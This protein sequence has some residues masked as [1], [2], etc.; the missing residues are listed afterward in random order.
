MSVENEREDEYIEAQK[1][2]GTYI[3]G[4]SY[5]REP[6]KD[7]RPAMM[8]ERIRERK[9]EYFESKDNEIVAPNCRIKKA[10][11]R[12]YREVYMDGRCANVEQDDEEQENS[13]TM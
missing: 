5:K 10:I 6:K 3:A 4:I 11:V 13:R 8:R 12:P 2:K 7:I 9:P 1:E